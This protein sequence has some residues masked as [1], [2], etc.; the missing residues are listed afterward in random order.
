MGESRLM[1]GHRFLQ[2]SGILDMPVNMF[3]RVHFC[4]GEISR[5]L[6]AMCIAVLGEYLYLFKECFFAVCKDT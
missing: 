4:M 2:L 5:S 1:M 3:E 6:L